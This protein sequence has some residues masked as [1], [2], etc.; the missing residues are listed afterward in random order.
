M[1]RVRAKQKAK[2]MTDNQTSEAQAPAPPLTFS[3]FTVAISL[4]CRRKIRTRTLLRSLRERPLAVAGRGGSYILDDD[5]AKEF[6]DY[7]R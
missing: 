4:W 2:G 1:V 6:M 5:F 3:Y 7:D